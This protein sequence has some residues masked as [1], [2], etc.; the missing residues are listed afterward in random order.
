MTHGH[1]HGFRCSTDIQMAL[2]RNITHRCG[3]WLCIRTTDQL[4]TLRATWTLGGYTNHSHQHGLQAE[5]PK[6]ITK[7]SVSGADHKCPI[8]ISSLILARGNTTTETNIASSGI[9]HHSGPSRISSYESE[10]FLLHSCPEPRNL[11][12]RRPDE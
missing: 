7:D 12:A 9:T 10:L 11:A 1:E 3:P 4:M 8:W 6:D 2:S 5:T